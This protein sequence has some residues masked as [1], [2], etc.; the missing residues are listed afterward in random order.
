MPQRSLLNKA[1]TIRQNITN[2]RK[3]NITNLLIPRRL[4]RG[5]LKAYAISRNVTIKCG[6]VWLHKAE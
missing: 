5:F 1:Y 3:V 4:L 6:K 2:S